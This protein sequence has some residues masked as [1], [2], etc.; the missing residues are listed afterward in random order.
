M[1]KPIRA[2]F[3]YATRIALATVIVAAFGAG[4]GAASAGAAT[5]CTGLQAALEHAGS[6]ATV[7]LDGMCTGSYTLPANATFTLEGAPGTTSGFEGNG[8]SVKPLL[9][10]LASTEAGAMTLSHLTFE[11][12]NLKEASALSLLASRVTL[13]DDSFLENEEHGENAHAAFVQIPNSNCPPAGSPAIT[14]TGSTFSRNKLFLEAGRGGGAGAWLEDACKAGSVLENNVFEGNLL[15][16]AGTHAE[17]VVSGAGLQFVGPKTRPVPVVS[18]RGNVF[19]S[20]NIVAAAPADA[21]YGGGG[22]WL[23]YASLRSV[24]D[25]FSRDSVPGTELEATSPEYAWSWGGGLGVWTPEHE[26]DP[27]AHPEST[28]EDAIVEDDSIGPGTPQDIGG[29]GVY[30]GCSHLTVLDSTFTLNTAYNGAA[31]EGEAGDELVLANSILAQGTGTDEIAGFDEEGGTQTTSFSDVCASA[32][33]SEPIPGTGNI[34]A[35]PLLADEGN[36]L[37]FDV[38]ETSS[39]PTID[40]GS[41]ALVPSE[42]TTDAYGTARILAGRTGCTATVDMGAAELVPVTPPP[43]TAPTQEQ[44]PAPTAQQQIPA[45]EL[46]SQ[47]QTP[48]APQA[49]FVSLELSSIG[50]GLRLSCAS[51]DGRGCSGAIYITSDEILKGKKVVAVDTSGGDKKSVRLGQASFSLAAGATATFHVKLNSTGLELLRHFHA[52][53]AWVLANEALPSNSPVVFLLHP[54]RF[55]EPKQAPKSSKR[56]PKKG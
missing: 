48:A 26:C 30:V 15:E 54:A 6:G 29:G 31:I 4:A 13:S 24:D 49:H 45:S 17:V 43:C 1:K 50:V 22:E 37:S 46:T 52:F 27:A 44:T 41:N 28:L 32:G 14:L 20:D 2:S 56:K 9:G 51:S 10:N 16:A 7:V 34:C 39:S 21:D 47:Q 42:L 25:R 12:A 53:S 11:H 36:P 5:G 3:A 23:E 33:S 8:A 38:H 40:A 35:D 55:T 19:D 18:Q